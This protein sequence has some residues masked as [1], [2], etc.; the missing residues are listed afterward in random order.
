MT[1]ELRARFAER[2]SAYLQRV[3]ANAHQFPGEWSEA[4]LQAVR[5]VLADRGIE[6]GKAPSERLKDLQVVSTMEIPGKLITDTPGVVS[7]TVVLGAGFL[8]ELTGS[9][10]IFRELARLDF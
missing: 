6:V 3:L 10:A 2:D 5:D 8:S 1:D 4:E 9:I 7:G